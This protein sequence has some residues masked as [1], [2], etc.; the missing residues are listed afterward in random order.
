ALGMTRAGLFTSGLI[1]MGVV[2]VAAGAGAVAVAA[3]LSP[4]LPVGTARIAEPHN[5]F[6]IDAH[7]L[8][9]GVIGVMVL[10]LVAGA[11]VLLYTVRR[12]TTPGS[13]KA[14]ARRSKATVGRLPLPMAT[15]VR[16]ALSPGRGRS[17]VPVRATLAAVTL[18]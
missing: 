12:S 14:P 16:F 11:G 2:A 9:L 18:G 5:G 7:A 6:S 1:R 4:L 8:A 13:G 3:L 17:A 10:L 15:G